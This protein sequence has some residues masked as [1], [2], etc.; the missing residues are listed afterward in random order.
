MNRPPV[1]TDSPIDLPQLFYEISHL[2]GQPA[3][4]PEKLRQITVVLRQTFDLE[5]IWLRTAEHGCGL[6]KGPL[7]DGSP[8]YIEVSDQISTDLRLLPYES[9]HFFQTELSDDP[10]VNMLFHSSEFTPVLAIPLSDSAGQRLGVLTVSD[11]LIDWQRATDTIRRLRTFLATTLTTLHRLDSAEQYAQILAQEKQ[12]QEIVDEFA[13][14]VNVGHSLSE[15]AQL[16]VAR[17]RA[18]FEFNHLSVALLG[19]AEQHLRQW[20]F[21]EHGCNQRH[22]LYTSLTDSVYGHV[23]ATQQPRLDSDI[24][25]LAPTVQQQP[26]YHLL[27]QEGVRARLTI[28]F[29]TV[30]GL[31]GALNL[32]HQKVGIYTPS[33]V[34][35]LKKIIPF[36]AM[37]IE[38]AHLVDT[39]EEGA[40][41]LKRL[42]HLG[43]ILATVTD[44]ERIIDLTLTTL[45]RLLTCDVQAILLADEEGLHIGTAVPYNFQRNRKTIQEICDTFIDV[46][47]EGI[48]TTIISS[49]TIPGNMP[50]TNA[51]QPEAVLS[52]PILSRQGMMGL[53]Y[54]AN[55]TDEDFNNDFLRI[56]SL[57]VSQISAVVENASLFRQVQRDHAQLSAI[58]VSSTDAILVVQR[59]GQIVLD[60]PAAWR[61]MG[62]NGSQQGR[63]LS[64]ATT[65]HALVDLFEQAMQGGKRNGEIT[66]PHEDERTMFANLSPVSVEVDKIIGWVATMQDVSHFKMLSDLKNDF[67][68]TVSHDLR[69]PLSSI[70]IAA[71]L[72][73]QSPDL[74]DTQRG[75]LDTIERK[76]KT[77][78]ELVHDLLDV[79]KIEA[80]I[81]FTFEPVDLPA[82]LREV[83]TSFEVD[84]QDKSI[85]LILD[86]ETTLPS[87]QGHRKR[88]QQVFQ[89]LLSN[90]IKYT[91]A[92][93]R[94]TLRATPHD[95][96]V[97]V[98]VSDTGL[99]IPVADQ[100]RI[101]EKFYRVR[102]EHVQSIKG[103]GLGLA[104]CKGIVEKHQG[105][106]WL[107]SVF[108]N[109]SKFTVALPRV[110][111]VERVTN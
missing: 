46:A 93:G 99:G 32:G 94:V 57:V 43:E 58:L 16:I 74:D 14:A 66:L 100:P 88:L 47:P 8:T 109:G 6:A 2:V 36:V 77:M 4:Y 25:R 24:T 67:V 55:G 53:I 34:R 103:T 91:P 80:D 65:N 84:A 76:V 28:P 72:I 95:H 26:D 70:L 27:L 69:S 10:M 13:L 45:P 29:R 17:L 18:L 51:W 19:E 7:V 97:R 79:G 33:T 107:E 54:A 73:G 101:F 102:G 111:P 9:P 37:M 59:N 1:T 85:S 98:E 63:L 11:G 50:V 35:L 41:K 64:A 106:I 23:L 30:N 52:L 42:H 22:D 83:V 3:T 90:A 78:R 105:R 71:H 110:S 62:V 82:L 21:Y 89:N 61:V 15:I 49:K 40:I 104:I 5:A 56:F 20:I 60:N 87:I 96:E 38:Q 12:E 108:G 44:V 48:P 92:G 31:Q 81:G 86:I 68:N 39:M 75:L